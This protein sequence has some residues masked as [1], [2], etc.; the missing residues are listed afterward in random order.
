MDD[1]LGR[2][3]G[4]YLWDEPEGYN[5]GASLRAR[6]AELRRNA[7]EWSALYQ[8]D[9]VP[10]SGGFFKRE[11]FKYYDTLPDNVR[12]YG[13]SDNAVTADGGDY[14]V[15]AIAAIDKDSNIYIKDIWREQTD[16]DMWVDALLDR[17]TRSCRHR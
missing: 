7:V 15:H 17:T 1:P 9:P 10:E 14:T 2:E 13:A 5:Y 3:P 12:T 4:E 8:Q 16:T 11:W 6:E